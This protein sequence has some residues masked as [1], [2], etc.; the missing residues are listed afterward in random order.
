MLQLYRRA[1]Y[2]PKG[3]LKFIYD[4]VKKHMATKEDKETLYDFL[5]FNKKEIYVPND[6]LF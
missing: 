5:Y 6:Y 4:A 2:L 3:S 1:Q